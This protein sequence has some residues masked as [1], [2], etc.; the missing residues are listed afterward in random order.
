VTE[1]G[2]VGIGTADPGAKLTVSG[3]NATVN[4]ETAEIVRLLR[5]SVTGVKNHNSAGLRVGAF[6]TGVS[7]ATRLDIALSGPA[8]TANQWGGV[9]DVTVMSLLANGNVSIKGS[10]AAG[11]GKG[12]YVMDQFV[13]KVA[14]TLEQGDIVVIGDNQ[15]SQYYGQNNNIPIPEIDLAQRVYDTRV[16]GI[17]TEVH[18]PVGPESGEISSA[19]TE[20]K[21]SKTA[22]AR[23]KADTKRQSFTPEELEKLDRTKVGSGQI[24]WMVTLGA[25]AH[26]KVDADIAPIK[27]GDLLTTSPTRGHAQKVLDPSQAFG[28]IVGKALGSLEKGKGKIPVLVMLQ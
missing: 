2:N 25:F 13:N 9:P 18:V 12:G 15:A 19:G 7:G 27:V 20:V 8:T 24:G 26:C 5:P 23:S 4:I 1:S 3:S 10:I 22:Q 28:A 14:D 16:C 17:V 11:G 21:K 6:E